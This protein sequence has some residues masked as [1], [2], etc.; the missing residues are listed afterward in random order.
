MNL[1][2]MWEFSFNGKAFRFSG[3]D[4]Y[5]RLENKNSELYLDVKMAIWLCVVAPKHSSV[6]NAAELDQIAELS[7]PDF[8][9]RLICRG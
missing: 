7:D 6:F 3:K 5:D 1:Y 9:L 4:I 2:S 8:E